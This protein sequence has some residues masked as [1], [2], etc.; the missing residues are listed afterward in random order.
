MGV[1]MNGGEGSK[2]LVYYKVKL[3]DWNVHDWILS[4]KVFEKSYYCLI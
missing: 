3:G 2:G 4:I 1:D